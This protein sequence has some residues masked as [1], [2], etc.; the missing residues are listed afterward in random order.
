MT[1]TS[2][3]NNSDLTVMCVRFV[4]ALHRLPA[5]H[6]KPGR[7][8]IRFES[9]PYHVEN[10]AG[11]NRRLPCATPRLFT[12]RIVIRNKFMDDAR[13]CQLVVRSLDTRA[14]GPTV[15][16]DSNAFLNRYYLLCVL[17]SALQINSPF[18]RPGGQFDARPITSHLGGAHASNIR[19]GEW[20][21][22]IG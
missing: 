16:I 12:M 13:R 5:L 2:H 4:V 21:P 17:L 19:H 20:P 14:D 10:R 9:L 3:S 15:V 6:D 18:E 8:A 7:S 11:T 22:L 1:R